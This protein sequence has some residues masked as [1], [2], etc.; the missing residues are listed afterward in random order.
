[1]RL[2][3]PGATILLGVLLLVRNSPADD[4]AAGL[5]EG[6]RAVWDLGRAVRESTSTRER[7]CINGLWRWQPADVDVKMPP[8]EH[9]G[10]FKVPGSWPGITNYMLKDC[11]TVFAH[12][13]WQDRKLADLTAAWYERDIA[14]PR[15][16][17]GRRVGLS[18]E[19]LNSVATVFIDG[20]LA[21]ELRYPGGML[22]LTGACMSGGLHRLTL[23]VSALPLSAVMVSYGD[24]NAAKEVKARVELRGLCGD[25]FLV[26]EPAT[27]RVTDV[28]IETSVCQGEIAFD[29][30][31]SD[32][33]GDGEYVLKADVSS[34]GTPVRA[35]TSKRFRGSDVAGERFGFSS[36]WL[37]DRLWDTHTPENQFDVSVALTRADDTLLDT[38]LPQ[39]FGFREF[40][41][42]GR[43]FY[44]NGSRIFLSAA[45]LDNAQ[46]C[47]ALA[48][49][50]GVRE[51]LRRLKHF[52]INFVYTHNYG[53]QPGSHLSFAEIL[54]A[55]DDEGMLVAFS[56]P[57]FSHY[58]WQGEDADRSN[59]YARHAEFY[60]RAAQNHPAVVA[61]SMNHNANGTGQDMNPDLIDGLNE[62]H[63]NAGQRENAGQSLRAQAI[64][65]A[66]DPSRV[67]YHHSGGNLGSMHTVNFYANFVPIQ[68]L[69]DWFEHWAS[70][71]TKPVFLCEFAA[72]HSWDW[73]MYRGW[74]QGVRE[75]GAARV[76]WDFCLAEWNA[77]FLGDR[78]Y[79][80]SD[81][82]RQNLRWEAK[83]FAAEKVWQRSQYPYDLSSNVFDERYPVFARYIA[84]NYRAFR[85]WGLSAYT[86]WLHWH[87]WKPREGIDRSRREL[88][89]DWEH[90]QRPGFSPDYFDQRYERHDLAFEEED[91]LP[92]AVAEALYRNNGPLLA[93]IGGKPGAFTS[94]DHTF[95]P[96]ETFQKQA[97]VINNSRRTVKCDCTWSLDLPRAISGQRHVT[98]PTGEQARVPLTIALPKDV[99]PG[100]YRLRAKF[101]FDSA[102]AQ[103]DESVVHVLPRSEP[104]RPV[105]NLAVFDPKGQTAAWLKSAGVG[106][107]TV[108]AAETL[109]LNDVLLVGRHALTLDSAA[110][111]ITAVREGL[112]VVM[113]EQSSQVLE[114]RLGFRTTE[115]GLRQLFPRA[116]DHPLLAGL[117]EKQLRD[118]R[119]SATIVPPQL[120]YETR[121]RLGP[122]VRWCGLEVPHIWRCGNRGNVSTVQIEKPACG[123]FLP[124]VDGGF[125][126]QYSPLMEHREGQGMMLFCQLDVTGRSETEPAAEKL[127]HNI[128]AYVSKWKPPP[129]RK[130]VYSGNDAGRRHL[131][132]AG[133][134]AQPF[135]GRLTSSQLL[136]VTPDEGNPLPKNRQA[137]VDFLTSGGY[138]LA[139]GL[140]QPD[141]AFLP[142][143]VSV[144]K[145]EHIAAWFE[146]PRGDSPLRGISP[147]DVHNRD[148]R[149]LPLIESGA[150][151][152]GDG[153]LATLRGGNVVLCQL[154]P[155]EFEGPSRQ[156]LKKTHRRTSFLLSRLL[157]N[158]GAESS[159]PILERFH[160]PLAE[161]EAPRWQTGLYLDQPEEWD[162]PY[163]FFRW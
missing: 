67:I 124:I 69:S 147:A 16:W 6:V 150:N 101:S 86:V 23:H 71:G 83:Q 90:L 144:R 140:D 116:P 84:D 1:M 22:D 109:S 113:F 158:L 59:G 42:E 91:W 104:A 117:G 19:C 121:P 63:N 3:L 143:E 35:F 105:T 78:A 56:Q 52:G 108:G 134:R 40:R 97:I 152:I 43:D 11:Q 57:H 48:T 161:G 73:G 9:W 66:L 77:Q 50:D 30:G 112:R 133:F 96:G 93:Y 163:R 17:G 49:Y 130:I 64:V 92:T 98:V 119:G 70:V 115:Y 31:L 34:G 120:A 80:I 76:P 47:A 25:A 87:F 89:V 37:P 5:P 85:T 159:T 99:T 61:Y 60:V 39:R 20:Q 155:W 106:F 127:L 135:E 137:V 156:N 7:V 74:Y 26:S 65:H 15:E 95:F 81:A 114:Q 151:P 58:G 24:T 154:A 142:G 27:E 79:D 13:S 33:K 128:L 153:V 148:P 131:E 10:Y 55:A 18:L 141:L 125:S 12:P 82:E 145:E 14:I 149:K 122:I 138:L 28:R 118:W 62:Q 29:C 45:P 36:K 102:D 129:P 41:I 88:P 107:R 44:L 160:T 2:P 51:S 4:F 46:V 21:G 111:D 53:C 75:F 162:D 8:V 132:S 110:P 123:S 94:K 136:V 146:A 72:P 157:S 139:V 103:E 126:L 32:L 54:R 38:A 68:E 100:E